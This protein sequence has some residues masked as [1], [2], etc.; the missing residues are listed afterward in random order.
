M[1]GRIIIVFNRNDVNVR[2]ETWKN[3]KNSSILH[4][5]RTFLSMQMT[6]LTEAQHFCSFQD[7]KSRDKK[8]KKLGNAV[9][10][11]IVI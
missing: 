2:S 7:E 10:K 4:G 6:S 3:A 11:T 9:R 1:R 5:R 8:K